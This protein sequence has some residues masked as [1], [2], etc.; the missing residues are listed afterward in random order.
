VAPYAAGSAR[1]ELI[2][3]LER[4]HQGVRLTRA[5]LDTIACWIDLYVPYCGDYT[6]A[7]L[8]STQ[9]LEKFRRF[10]AKR[11][12]FEGV[13]GHDV[14]TGKLIGRQGGRQRSVQPR[15]LN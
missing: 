2:A 14:A 1:S 9:E 12:S 3:L 11:R 13:E 4:G 10:E 5:E 7:N 15:V 6:E 8:W